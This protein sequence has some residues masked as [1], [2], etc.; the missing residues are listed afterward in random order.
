M[1][2]S[3][4]IALMALGALFVWSQQVLNRPGPG[5][6]I[7]NGAAIAIDG[8]SLRVNGQE[9]RLQG[10]DAPEFLQTCQRAGKE[11]AC[12]REAAASLRKI[13]A[14]GPVTCIG[15]E[16]DR[17]AR[18]LVTCR[19]M[20]TDIAAVQVKTGM[21]VSYGDYLV[22]EAEARNDNRGVW[23]GTFDMPREWRA[24]HPSHRGAPPAAPQSQP[25]SP[26]APSH[27]P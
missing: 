8:D 21:A 19:I 6:I 26:P 2:L 13:L 27:R 25:S 1:R 12:G 11:V 4:L 18:L 9:M 3:T 24:L 22:E 7:S 20:G 16:R 23:S 17:Y 5:D 10:I 15:T 14:R